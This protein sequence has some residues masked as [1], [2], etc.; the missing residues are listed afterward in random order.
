[1]RSWACN[2]S[3]ACEIGSLSSSPKTST[4]PCKQIYPNSS[5]ILLSNLS[6]ISTPSQVSILPHFSLGFPVPHR[7]R[8]S[9]KLFDGSSQMS[10]SLSSL[11]PSLL[12][13][14]LGLLI[15]STTT[16]YLL[17]RRPPKDSI[18]NGISSL[19]GHTALLKIP[20][21]SAATG[22]EILAKT[23]VS[24]TQPRG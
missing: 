22:C 21:L 2:Y 9:F 5:Y 4:A 18:S 10:P 17:L 14:S 19:I 16:T 12:L 23:E 8:R 24:P 11:P 3:L 13:L 1:M 7:D 20:S 6:S 15:G